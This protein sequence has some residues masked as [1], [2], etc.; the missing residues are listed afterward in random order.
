M[1]G[2]VFKAG[3]RFNETNF[4]YIF[5]NVVEDSGTCT[6]DAHVVLDNEPLI[7]RGVISRGSWF[8]VNDEDAGSD[9]LL[10]VQAPTRAT[11]TTAKK[12]VKEN[13]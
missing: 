12:T 5:F 8:L 10:S 11:K 1:A 13:E 4:K 3:I 6:V 9:P 7:L 2:R